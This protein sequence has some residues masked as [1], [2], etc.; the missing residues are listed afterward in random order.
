MKCCFCKETITIGEV[1]E[2]KV[3]YL[4]GEWSHISCDEK[5]FEEIDKRTKHLY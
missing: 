2:R 4:L 5:K 3:N 1:K